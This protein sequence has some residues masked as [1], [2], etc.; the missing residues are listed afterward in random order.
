M[1]L[2]DL[3]L[4]GGGKRKRANSNDSMKA[5]MGADDSKLP[6][7]RRQKSFSPGAR[8]GKNNRGMGDL[9]F[10]FKTSPPMNDEDDADL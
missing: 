1:I 10:D 5:N 6:G 4:L 3:D 9:A 2:E 7:V 8:K